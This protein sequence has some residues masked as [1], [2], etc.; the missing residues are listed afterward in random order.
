MFCLSSPPLALKGQLKLTTTTTSTILLVFFL[1]TL[2]ITS[3]EARHLRA[4]SK[5]SSN[6]YT[7]TSKDKA[8]EVGDTEK[9][10]RTASMVHGTGKT[11]VIAGSTIDQSM[12]TG[13]TLING[14]GNSSRGSNG[15]QRGSKATT[16][17]TA[18]TLVAM[19]YPVARAAP[20]VHNR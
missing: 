3:C 6:K 18:G 2:Y 10:I 16:A 4:N 12:S 19:D 9:Q 11:G 5:G 17:Y 15:Q 7:L 1:F 14:S 20:A 8:A 13:A